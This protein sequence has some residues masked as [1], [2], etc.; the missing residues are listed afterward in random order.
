M[1][2]TLGD[3]HVGADMVPPMRAG[4]RKLGWSWFSLTVGDLWVSS[5]RRKIG[6]HKCNQPGTMCTCLGCE[7][8][9]QVRLLDLRTPLEEMVDQHWA[10]YFQKVS[11]I[12]VSHG[13]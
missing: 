11:K 4:E 2:G 12:L 3:T 7:H 6:G 5:G 8:L 9:G 13:L 10:G 1:L